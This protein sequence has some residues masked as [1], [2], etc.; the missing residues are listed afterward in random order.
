MHES[1][2]E[3]TIIDHDNGFTMVKTREFE[4]G[5]ESYVLPSLP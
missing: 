1:D 3:R 5:T 4:S 2:H